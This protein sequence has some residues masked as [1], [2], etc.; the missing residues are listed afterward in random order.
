MEHMQPIETDLSFINTL[1]VAKHPSFYFLDILKKANLTEVIDN[2]S[3]VSRELGI[4]RK[5]FYDFIR[6][7][8]GISP[9]MAVRLAAFFKKYLPDNKSACDHNYWWNL[10]SIWYFQN[11]IRKL[12]SAEQKP[13]YTFPVD[14]DN[15]L[16]AAE[17][18]DT[19]NN[20]K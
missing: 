10:H 12:N 3:A 6:G 19:Y 14:Y 1:E 13:K 18:G 5:G 11:E 7:S 16:S 4:S 8:T 15:L 9:I 2:V 20:E 17:S